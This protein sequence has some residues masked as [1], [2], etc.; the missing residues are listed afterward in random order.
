MLGNWLKVKEISGKPVYC[1][2]NVLTPGQCL[3]RLAN[4]KNSILR[5]LNSKNTVNVHGPYYSL[6]TVGSW[7]ESRALWSTLHRQPRLHQI[8][9]A[10]YKYPGR[11]TC[12]RIQVE[13]GFYNNNNTSGY[14]SPW[15]QFCRRY[16]IHVD[17]DRRYKWIQLVSGLHVSGV[18]AALNNYSKTAL[19]VVLAP[20]LFNI[21]GGGP[22]IEVPR[23]RTPKAWESRRIGV[24]KFL[25]CGS[26]NVNT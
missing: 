19:E 6:L 12:I 9:V 10:V 13:H 16:R 11:A 14:M 24:W 21:G 2:L 20:S 26:Q 1:Y 5:P 8:H 7:V 18:N 22:L 3:R 15:R 23:G 17:G 25:D 4:A